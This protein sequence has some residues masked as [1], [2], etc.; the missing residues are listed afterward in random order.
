MDILKGVILAMIK[1]SIIIISLIDLAAIE[2][3]FSFNFWLP[4]I[5]VSVK[6]LVARPLDMWLKML[7]LMKGI[8]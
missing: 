1:Y 2:F 3:L 8:E 6:V 4:L 5:Y 7:T